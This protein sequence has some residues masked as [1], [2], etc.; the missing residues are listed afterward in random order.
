MTAEQLRV[1]AFIGALDASI[2]RG[3]ADANAGRVRSSSEVFD[4]LASRLA[5]GGYAPPPATTAKPLP[6]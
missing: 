5:G 2:A 4:D 6:D 1:A 3:V